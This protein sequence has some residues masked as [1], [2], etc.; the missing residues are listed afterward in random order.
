MAELKST[1]TLKVK[2]K[3]WSAIKLRIAG[4]NIKEDQEI[5]SHYNYLEKFLED[6]EADNQYFTS[7]DLIYEK[8]KIIDRS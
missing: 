3:L 1:V 6:H 5:K 8:C 2:L 7:L 4:I